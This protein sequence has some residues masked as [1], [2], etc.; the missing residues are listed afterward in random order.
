MVSIFDIRDSSALVP[1]VAWTLATMG[2]SFAAFRSFV[3]AEI[4]FRWKRWS[5]DK[6]VAISRIRW[7]LHHGALWSEE[8]AKDPKNPHI[9]RHPLD[10]NMAESRRKKLDVAM[11]GSVISRMSIHLL[12]CALCQNFWSAALLFGLT[13]GWDDT[14]ALLVSSIAYATAAATIDSFLTRAAKAPSCSH[15]K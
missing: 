8:L 7:E 4:V 12:S 11:R 14:G 10:S 13:A 1:F 5:Q 2:V 15:H 3:A 6:S 9:A